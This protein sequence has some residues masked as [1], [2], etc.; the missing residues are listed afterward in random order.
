MPE[1]L[2]L[3][4]G[5]AVVDWK[6]AK[7]PPRTAIV[8]TFCRVEPLNPE[9]HL[10]DLY[11]AF[12]EDH[13]GNLWTYMTTG[14]FNS[15]EELGDWLESA[16]ATDDPQFHTIIDRSTGKAV[17]VAAYMRIK[18]DMGVIEIGNITYSPRLQR[19]AAATEAMFLFMKRVFDD[20]GYRRYE[21][22]CD[23]LNA[24]SRKAAERLGFSFDGL[25]EQAVV[26][27]GRNRDTAW[28]SI[29]DRHW[30]PLRNAFLKWLDPANFDDQG[31]QKHKLQYF[32]PIDRDNSP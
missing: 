22:K 26:Y 12:S 28:Y 32:V 23:S 14:P 7:T 15:K 27:K 20:L 4:V 6:V 1:K 13:E 19:T 10:D 8:G 25:F 3:P 2:E 17:G 24:A 31:R 18:P 5:T 9:T 16:A 11:D 29:L 21:W 30:P